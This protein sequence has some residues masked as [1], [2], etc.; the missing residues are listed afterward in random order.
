MN[1]QWDANERL[2]SYFA[3]IVISFNHWG[4]VKDYLKVIH[5]L[6]FGSEKVHACLERGFLETWTI[7]RGHAANEW[8]RYRWSILVHVL[9]DCLGCVGSI[10]FWHWIIHQDESIWVIGLLVSLLDFLLSF[11]PIT[12]IICLHTHLLKQRLVCHMVHDAI[13]NYKDLIEAIENIFRGILVQL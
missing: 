11:N 4:F 2:A 9:D 6:K 1:L 5:T 13:I 10:A 7:V 8:S 12:D 3:C